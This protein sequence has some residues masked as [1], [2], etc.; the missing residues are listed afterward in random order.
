[1]GR[2]P[3]IALPYQQKLNGKRRHNKLSRLM[4]P[5]MLPNAVINAIFAAVNA[6]VGFALAA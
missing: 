1:M 2:G 5:T 3:K 6:A 4:R